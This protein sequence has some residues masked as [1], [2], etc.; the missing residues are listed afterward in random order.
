META[1][2]RSLSDTM[3]CLPGGPP[4][5]SP[6]LRPIRSRPD[7]ND[8]SS[9]NAKSHRAGREIR[10][11]GDDGHHFVPARAPENQVMRGIMNDDV[12]GVIAERADA[13]GDQQT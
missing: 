2:A 5:G 12:V 6:G 10:K 11:I 8:V 13:K 4:N 9:G 1:S 3:S 7:G